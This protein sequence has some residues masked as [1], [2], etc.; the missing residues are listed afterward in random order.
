VLQTVGLGPHHLKPQ[1]RPAWFFNRAQYGGI[2]CDIASHQFDQFLYFTGSTKAEVVASQIGNLAH[3]QYP[4]LED[5]GDALLRGDGGTGYLRIDWFTPDGL[6][7]WGDGRLTI[8]GTDG[9]IELRKYTDL[10]GR[11]GANHLFLADQKQTRYIDCNDVV[12][13]F[14]HE[15]VQDVLERTDKALPQEHTF[16]ACELAL[17][18]QARAA[19]IA[20]PQNAGQKERAHG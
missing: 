17:T 14:G 18:A 4:E 9:Y 2:L 3:P 6:G 16:L 11:S 10:G 12:L 19:R 15:L 20:P 5:F 1:T 13:P 7:V 8:L